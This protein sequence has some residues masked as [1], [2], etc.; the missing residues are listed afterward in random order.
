MD[1]DVLLPKAHRPCGN[2]QGNSRSG[3]CEAGL[4]LASAAWLFNPNKLGPHVTDKELS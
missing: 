3:P 4:G 2:P 1:W